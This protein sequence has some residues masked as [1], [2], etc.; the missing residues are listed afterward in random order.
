M[1]RE[2]LHE[3]VRP[4]W[5]S[6]ARVAFAR[7]LSRAT[8]TI[9]APIRASFCAVARDLAVG[10][11]DIWLGNRPTEAEVKRLSEAGEFAKYRIV[12]FATHGA[13]AGQVAGNS[14]RS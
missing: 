2:L 7:A 4:R 9:R 1:P 11:K 6:R 8:R 14:E 10:D 3:L 13:L 12:R 5:R